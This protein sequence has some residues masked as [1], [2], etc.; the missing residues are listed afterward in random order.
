MTHPRTTTWLCAAF[1]LGL[2]ASTAFDAQPDPG[3]PVAETRDALRELLGAEV[4][5]ARWSAREDAAYGDA[6]DLLGENGGP[7][8]DPA[9]LPRAPGAEYEIAFLGGVRGIPPAF[10][11]WTP[12]ETLYLAPGARS[13][14]EIPPAMHYVRVLD[15]ER[16]ETSRGPLWRAFVER[17]DV[18]ALLL[19]RL[20]G[21]SPGAPPPSRN[22]VPARPS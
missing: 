12:G 2:L 11:G 17:I 13:I 9:A 6:R 5:V 4:R 8:A 1:L 3:P 7:G 16:V 21:E 14:H 18:D 20:A 10:A 22:E 15:V 19:P